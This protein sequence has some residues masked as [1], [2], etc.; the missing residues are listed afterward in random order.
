MVGA[1]DLDGW[2]LTAHWP[3]RWYDCFSG[4]GGKVMNEGEGSRGGVLEYW[5]RR[6]DQASK[7]TKWK[8]VKYYLSRAFDVLM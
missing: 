2:L 7:A 1:S 4:V 3:V 6:A 8:K 5:P